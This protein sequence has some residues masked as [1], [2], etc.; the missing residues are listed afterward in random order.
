MVEDIVGCKW[1]LSVLGC[2]RAGIRRPGAIQR[3]VEGLSTK[4]MNQ[5][6]RKL[7]RYGIVERRSYAEIPPRVEYH[8]TTFGRAFARLLDGVERLQAELDGAR[9]RSR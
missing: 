9:R 4:V 7:A 5:R 8:L 2:V 1:S 3:S 6:L